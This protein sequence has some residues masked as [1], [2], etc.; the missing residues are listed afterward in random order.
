MLARGCANAFCHKQLQIGIAG[1]SHQIDHPSRSVNTA[2]WT[3]QIQS[4]PDPFSFFFNRVLALCATGPTESMEMWL[5]WWEYHDHR[6]SE[7]FSMSNKM[8]QLNLQRLQFLP[9]LS[10]LQSNA[11]K[12]GPAVGSGPFVAGV[13][14]VRTHFIQARWFQGSFTFLRPSED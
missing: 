5:T 7:V 12:A 8:Q 10:D 9:V 6:N 2:D 14:L 13:E 1:A 4:C 3:I 11:S